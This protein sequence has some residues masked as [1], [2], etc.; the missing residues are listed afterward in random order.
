M[1][2]RYM[3]DQETILVSWVGLEFIDQET[4]AELKSS[5]KLGVDA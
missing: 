4:T 2:D 1:R 3:S 5:N